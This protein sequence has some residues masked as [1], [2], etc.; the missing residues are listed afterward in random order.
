[1]YMVVLNATHSRSHTSVPSCRVSVR[2]VLLVAAGITSQGLHSL[3]EVTQFGWFA[4]K[5]HFRVPVGFKCLFLPDLPASSVYST[6]RLNWYFGASNKLLILSLLHLKLQLRKSL[7]T[8]HITLLHIDTYI[9]SRSSHL[10]STFAFSVLQFYY[11]RNFLQIHPEK[12]FQ[13]LCS[14]L[15]SEEEKSS[16]PLQ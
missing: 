10:K 3:T 16:V 6:C 2:L 1:M 4:S 15:I 12:H 13:Q 9:T 14:D 11:I 5:N 8:L 7:F